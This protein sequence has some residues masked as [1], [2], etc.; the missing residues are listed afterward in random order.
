VNQSRFLP[1]LD[2]E[3]LLRFL[4]IPDQYDAVSQFIDFISEK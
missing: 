1:D 4:A 2:K 3:L